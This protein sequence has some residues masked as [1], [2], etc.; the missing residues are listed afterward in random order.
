MSKKSSGLTRRRMLTATAATCAAPWLLSGCEQAPAP[1]PGRKRVLRLAHLTDVHVQP[2]R[3]A[4]EGMAQCLQHV[5]ALDDP[6]EMILFG[7]DNIMDTF[8]NTK[9]RGEVQ[10]KLWQKTLKDHCKLPFKACIGNHDVWGWHKERSQTTGS[11]PG[12]GKE[13]AIDQLQ[14]PGR[15][16][17]FDQNG[18]HFIVL[19]STH[20]APNNPNSYVARLDDEQREWLAGDL[21]DTPND[22]PVLVLS[23]MPILTVTALKPDSDGPYPQFRVD[24]SNMHVDSLFIRRIF[25]KYGNVKLAVSG[26]THQLDRCEFHGTTY[27]CNGAVCGAWWKG[28]RPYCDEGYALI[29]LYDDS[30]FQIQYVAY[31]WKVREV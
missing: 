22:R 13:W 2:E 16:Y 27:C 4:G 1:P 26:H 10:W 28:D 17:S 8:A 5:H 25:E 15:F 20:P 29:D 3:G 21:Q 11:E 23:H 30:T 9:Q 31:H 7:G 24:Q 12:W 6:P 18:W 19:D 14:L